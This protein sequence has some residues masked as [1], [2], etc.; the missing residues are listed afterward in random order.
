MSKD[1]L[2]QLLFIFII[3]I[4]AF[5]IFAFDYGHPLSVVKYSIWDVIFP[6]LSFLIVIIFPCFIGVWVI[7]K[8]LYPN[9]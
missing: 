7:Y 9:K 1:Y 4:F 6:V 3:Q 2:V 8:T 5:Q